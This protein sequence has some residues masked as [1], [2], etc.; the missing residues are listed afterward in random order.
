MSYEPVSSLVTA[1]TL[2]PAAST[3]S[4]GAKGEAAGD[5]KLISG[6]TEHDTVWVQPAMQVE[7]SVYRLPLGEHV[8]TFVGVASQR[9][10]AAT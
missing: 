1:I 9:P 6:T 4:M 8:H 2:P 7:L 5:E 3:R 10:L